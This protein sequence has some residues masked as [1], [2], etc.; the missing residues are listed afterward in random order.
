MELQNHNIAHDDWD[1]DQLADALVDMARQHGIPALL[2]QD[3]HYCN[4]PDA[5]I[6]MADLT[7]KAL[8]K[9]E[10]GDKVIGWEREDT[11]RKFVEAEVLAV[12]TRAAEVFE[13]TMA[14]G[15]KIKC[16]ADHQW[17]DARKW[18]Y[19]YYDGYP[20]SSP[21][22]GMSLIKMVEPKLYQYDQR[23]AGWVGGMYDGEGSRSRIAQSPTHNSNVCDRIERSL[24]AL[25]FDYS[26]TNNSSGVNLYG[27]KNGRQGYV[28]FINI[29][30]PE[31]DEWFRKQIIG[32]WAS[33]LDEDEIV[34]MKSL[35]LQEVISMTTT[36][37]NYVA[38][39]YASKN[40][41]QEDKTVHEALKRL[42]AFGPDPD[43]AVFPGDGFHLADE[44][45]MRE[46]HSDDR[47]GYGLEG[48]SHLFDQ[49]DL[50]IPQLEKYRYNIPFTTAD[51]QKS[52]SKR[53]TGEA[54]VRNL[55]RR[56][57]DRLT[58]ELEVVMDTG[59]AGYLLLVADVTDWC[60]ENHVF[61]QARGSASGSILCWLLGITQVDPL[62]HGLRFERF[63]S[64][65]RTKP[66]DI[67]LDVEHTRRA[68][69][70]KWLETRFS[71]HQI[72]TWQSHSIEG[73]EETGK[74]SLRVKYFSK[75]RA[76]GAPVAS[77]ADV[78]HGDKQALYAL[79]DMEAYNSYGVHAAGVVL[80]TNSKEF[81]A[82]V[83]MMKVASSSTYVTQ[84]GMDDIEA[85]G[86]VKLDILGLKT[87]SVLHK[88]MEFMGRDVFDGLGWI[89][90][91]DKATY[92]MIAA[93][94]TEGV[95]QLEGWS[96]KNGVKELKPTKLG[97]VIASMALFRKAT[98]KSGATASYIKRRHK[99]EGIPERHVVI[100]RNTKDTYG[101]ALYQEQ[102]IAILRELGMDP[103]NLTRFLKAIKASNSSIGDAASVIAGYRESIWGMAQLQRMEEEDF[104][105]LWGAVEGFAEYGFN[106]CVSADTL[107]WYAC[108]MPIT[109][110]AG[111]H[112]SGASQY[113]T[114]AITVR[115][116]ADI[117]HGIPC[118]TR[119][120]YRNPKRGLMIA[121]HKDGKIVLDRA[122]GVQYTGKQ[123]VYEMTLESGHSI[124]A[125]V[126]HRHLTKRGWVEQFDI[127][128]GVDEVATMGDYEMAPVRGMTK[129][130][131]YGPMGLQEVRRV[132]ASLPMECE[133][134]GKWE[135]RM[136]V[137]HLDHD[138]TNNK[139][140]NLKRMCNPCHKQHDYA[141]GR[142]VKRWNKGRKIVWSKVV[143]N[144]YAG[145][146]DTFDIEMEGDDHSWVGNGIVTH[147]S[148]AAAYGLT[149]YRCAYL[150]RHYPVQFCAA[151]L[152]V[153]AGTDK[154]DMYVTAARRR[155]ISVRRPDVNLSD[156]SYTVDRRGKAIR[157]G[158]LAVKGLGKKTAEVIVNRRPD[159]GYE[160]MEHFCQVVGGR[161]SGAKAFLETGDTEVG[162][163][164]ALVEVGAFG[165]FE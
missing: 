132:Y 127:E 28:D 26:V 157:R 81:S 30:H 145:E 46:R 156:Q 153:A 86:L 144:E 84:Y 91:T 161:V 29:C 35:G 17:V 87:L 135:G 70:I 80:T 41:N 152:S 20:Y 37:G 164:G 73:D 113:N 24:A 11:Y 115:E 118:P 97:D 146:E 5:P 102:I 140:E 142:R 136:E 68:E 58:D 94:D 137:A 143:S 4:T 50:E 57:F 125:T 60:R 162:V 19:K 96:A 101:I 9:I 13:L 77:W 165:G 147:N 114:A 61:Y 6:W 95:F 124:K 158:L 52:L 116:Y 83:P 49:H 39:G 149:A 92:Q 154:E 121:A 40:C 98:M 54:T 138:R 36:S 71:V 27:I 82:L 7:H 109:G 128:P 107:M 130:E 33:L 14:S 74:G 150:A 148:H 111:A 25:G 44:Q 108:D 69:L 42:V 89:P 51:P 63:I 65:D 62:Q 55:G 22:V 59:M 21:T 110:D 90:L 72:G 88:C 1:D 23:T 45:W 126:N 31:R 38:W 105:W 85:L 159:N 16:T 43:D 160:S 48:L 56:Y 129:D 67:D 133:V 34:S 12:N 104:H 64:R 76:A 75:A 103:E 3:A 120:K 141:T 18:R 106:K 53:V 93:G 112:R 10:V 131:F 2:T 155:G 78:P 100:Q 119:S 139:R 8:R 117:Y 163:F 122:I 99:Q 79:G 47:F 66:P 134:C 123:P 15:K 32:S 151:L